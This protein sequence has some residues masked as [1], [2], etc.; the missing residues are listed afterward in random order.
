MYYLFLFDVITEKSKQLNLGLPDST[1][2]PREVIGRI[3]FNKTKQQMSIL[4]LSRGVGDCGSYRLFD[5]I[6]SNDLNKAGFQQ[7]EFRQQTCKNYAPE[8]L[9]NLPKEIFDYKQWPLVK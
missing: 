9:D 8:N 6:N 3:E 7:T 5:F 2:N 4:S 1:D